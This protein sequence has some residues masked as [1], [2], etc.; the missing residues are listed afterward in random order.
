[1]SR[2][3]PEALAAH[4]AGAVTT[5]AFLWTLTRRDG[6]VLGFTSHDADLVRAGQL[7]RAAPSFV[8]SAIRQSS[9]FTADDWQVNGVLTSAAIT[10][11]DLAAGRYDFARVRIT[12][13]DWTDP[14][15]EGVTLAVGQ[16]GE[17]RAEDAGFTAELRSLADRLSTTVTERYSPECRA[18]LGD[19]RCRVDLARHT[20]RAT[21]TGLV[22]AH[23]FTAGGLAAV[24]DWYAYGRLRWLD[25]ANGGLAQEIRGSGAGTITLHEP[26]PSPVRVGDRFEA[27]AGCDRRF[28]TCGAKFANI[29]NFRGEPHVPGTDSLLDYPGL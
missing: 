10:A 21:V 28:A 1:M 29:V 19:R 15:G 4:L 18:D 16:L 27:R 2:D 17:V 23:R 11:A 25:G 9:D 13:V 20:V 6:V 8:P 22:D 26:P 3:V 12:L 7:Y 5:L 24:P 14:A